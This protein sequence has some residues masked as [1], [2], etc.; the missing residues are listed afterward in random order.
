M[1]WPIGYGKT[2]L[3]LWSGE[4]GVI[5]VNGAPFTDQDGWVD[6]PVS[7][8]Q[9]ESAR[10]DAY[11]LRLRLRRDADGWPFLYAEEIQLGDREYV[12]L[13]ALAKERVEH[14]YR[15]A[16]LTDPLTGI[17]NRRG[18][19]ERAERVIAR[20][21][22]SRAPLTLLVC[23]LDYFKSINDR[24]GHIVGDELLV[25]FARSLTLSLR[26]LDLVGRFGGEEFV[27]LLPDIPPEATFEV[28]ERVRT[29]FETIGRTV[30]GREVAATVSIGTA[31]TALADYSATDE[32]SAALKA[33]YSIT[34]LA[35]AD[36]SSLD[37]VARAAQQLGLQ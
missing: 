23:D 12:G 13:F 6:L 20:C 30:A 34:K 5:Y 19:D 29:T 32:G 35:P 15:M 22:V 37:V 8:E 1:S 11:S 4:D 9:R 18:F 16:S 14:R 27:A 31:S 36:P 17:A 28:A 10:V 24:F 33:V 2:G 21:K 3:K 25:A 26:P 7:S